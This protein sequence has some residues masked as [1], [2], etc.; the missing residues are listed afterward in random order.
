MWVLVFATVVTDD[1]TS[2]TTPVV[3]LRAFRYVYDKYL[4]ELLHCVTA[5]GVRHT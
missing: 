5:E 3:A 1:W 2:G 4:V